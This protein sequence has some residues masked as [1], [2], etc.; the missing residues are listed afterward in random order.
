VP[1]QLPSINANNTPRTRK[2]PLALYVILK[3]IVINHNNELTKINYYC[4]G[5]YSW[6][7]ILE[8]GIELSGKAYGITLNNEVIPDNQTTQ[9]RN[10]YGLY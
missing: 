6:V 9:N 3:I 1:A 8:A 5:I 2:K 7:H 10:T 4:S